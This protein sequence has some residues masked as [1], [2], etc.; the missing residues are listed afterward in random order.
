MYDSTTLQRL[1]LAREDVSYMFR[2]RHFF[3]EPVSYSIFVWE[4]CCFLF[5]YFGFSG[6][7]KCC[8]IHINP[9]PSSYGMGLPIVVHVIYGLWKNTSLILTDPLPT[10]FTTKWISLALFQDTG[11]PDCVGQLRSR[12]KQLATLR[13][14]GEWF[15]L[16]WC[17]SIHIWAGFE[18]VG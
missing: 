16:H 14:S 18:Q 15:D 4:P 3:R 1:F 2:K 6:K 11:V 12:W 5:R 9:Y 17:S 7:Y 10:H 8:M 13:R